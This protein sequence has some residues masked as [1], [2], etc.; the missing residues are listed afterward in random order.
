MVMMMDQDKIRAAADKQFPQAISVCDAE[1]AMNIRGLVSLFSEGAEKIF[2]TPS[3]DI[4]NGK[5]LSIF[6]PNDNFNYTEHEKQILGVFDGWIRELAMGIVPQGRMMRGRKPIKFECE[7]YPT[8]H[9]KVGFYPLFVGM[10]AKEIIASCSEKAAQLDGFDTDK[11]VDWIRNKLYQDDILHSYVT[12][13]LTDSKPEEKVSADISRLDRSIV[14]KAAKSNAEAESTPTTKAGDIINESTGL[15]S[16]IGAN[17]KTLLGW[18][19]TL[20][21]VV[22]GFLLYTFI[23]SDR[24][25]PAREQPPRQSIYDGIEIP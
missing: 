23:N 19:A 24:P 18:I 10:E 5:I 17:N 7:Q 22:G 1:L 6:P 9:A 25:M 11:K 14:E 16:V 2:A 15:L 4:L 20:L 13:Y 12:I 21:I 3:M 8:F